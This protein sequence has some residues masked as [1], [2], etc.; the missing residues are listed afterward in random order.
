MTKTGGT[1]KRNPMLSSE[2]A[3]VR[4]VLRSFEWKKSPPY[5]K[6]LEEMSVLLE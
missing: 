1:T 3:T 6:R 5:W 4:W 2:D